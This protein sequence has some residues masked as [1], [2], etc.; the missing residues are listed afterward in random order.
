MSDNYLQLRKILFR[1]PKDESSLNFTSGVNV[2]CGASDTGK[3]FLA[4]SIDFM[5]GGSVLRE[6]PELAKYAEIELDLNVSDGEDWR[7]LRS[8]LGGN[9]KLIDLNEPNSDKVVLKQNHAHGKTDNLSSFLLEKIGLLGKR[10]LK[11]ST[12]ATT[13][14]LSFRNLARLSLFRK[15]KSS[16]GDH[17]SGAVSTPPRRLS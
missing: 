1:G 16:K 17:R 14:S 5:L 4:E 10:I 3:S 11:S 15:E 6:I 13:Q 7:F 9:F 8:V 12:K 2:I